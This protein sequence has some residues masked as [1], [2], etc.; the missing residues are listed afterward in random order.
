MSKKTINVGHALSRDILVGVGSQVVTAGFGILATFLLPSAEAKQIAVVATFIACATVLGLLFYLRVLRRYVGI[1]VGFEARCEQMHRL[2]HDA[3][4]L[5]IQASKV[6]PAY[7]GP[8][9]APSEKFPSPH[10]GLIKHKAQ[11]QKM[12]DDLR[13]LFQQIAPP[14]AKVW[15][16]LRD[17][18][19]DKGYYTYIRSGNYNRS[20]ERLSKP[21]LR[22]SSPIIQKLHQSF[23]DGSCVIITGSGRGEGWWEGQKNDE[24]DEDLSVMMGVVM[25]RS[26]D[27]SGGF[28]N[29]K[30]AWIITVSADKEDV[31]H[32][33]HIP[34]MKA[35]NDLFSAAANTILR[36]EA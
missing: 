13:D 5:I 22:D 27:L 29:N 35:C 26:W 32:E 23:L 15:A 20:R 7:D 3:R 19:S 14:G 4:D 8:S 9:K 31:F 11:I 17:R 12:L 30:H 10:K 6:C 18:R 1:A 2:A 28:V 34:L 24:F 36:E 16:A 25:T 21:L 33:S